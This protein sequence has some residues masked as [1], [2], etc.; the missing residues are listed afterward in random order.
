[1]VPDID[2]C[3]NLTLIARAPLK[4]GM[5][6]EK[7]HHTKAYSYQLATTDL[8]SILYIYLTSGKK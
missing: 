6:N 4:R 3:G 7:F 1:M 8:F 2:A 5:A